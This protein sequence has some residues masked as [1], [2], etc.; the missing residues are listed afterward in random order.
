[1]ISVIAVGFV[2]VLSA[3]YIGALFFAYR[4]LRRKSIWIARIT[5]MV[6]PILTTFAG[7]K[8]W[9]TGSA[10]GDREYDESGQYYFQR[11]S[12]IGS[13]AFQMSMPGGGSDS[14]DGFIRLYDSKG[15]L[16]N[17]YFTVYLLG[18]KPTWLDNSLW[19]MG[20][21]DE[22]TWPLQTQATKAREQ[23]GAD[24]PATAPQLKS[25]HKKNTKPQLEVRPR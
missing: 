8:V 6:L 4:I 12:T 25:E 13:S 10:Y 2:I 1:M 24:Q 9:H 11:Y 21:S 19:L 14:I 16:L 22:I 23:G 5:I 3:I 17:E 20:T 18:I 7:Y 15:N